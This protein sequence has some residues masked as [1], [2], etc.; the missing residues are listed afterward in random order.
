MSNENDKEQDIKKLHEEMAEKYKEPAKNLVSGDLSQQELALA[1]FQ[2]LAETGNSTFITVI[3]DA[4]CPDPDFTLAMAY[5][6][7]LIVALLEHTIREGGSKTNVT[8]F[9]F[10]LG[11]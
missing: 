11:F 8:P 5:R 3:W 2:K 7:D 9:R 4:V 6:E 1:A 10:D